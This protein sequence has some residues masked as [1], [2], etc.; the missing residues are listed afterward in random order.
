MR[1]PQLAPNGQRREKD[2]RGECVVISESL[3]LTTF[4]HN[5]AGS[6]IIAD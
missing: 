1:F 4:P 3:N 6:Q 5:V 2:G